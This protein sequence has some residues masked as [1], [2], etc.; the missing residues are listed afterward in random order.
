MEPPAIAFCEAQKTLL[1]RLAAF[2]ADSEARWLLVSVPRKMGTTTALAE[3]AARFTRRD[4]L[5]VTADRSNE[6]LKCAALRSGVPL[7]RM[8][9]RPGQ[10]QFAELEGPAR[11]VQ[12][13]HATYFNARKIA[14]A[15]FHPSERS[16]CT[17]L[18]QLIYF[19]ASGGRPL[20]L[21]T[22]HTHISHVPTHP[23]FVGDPLFAECFADKRVKTAIV[24]VG[25]L[26]ARHPDC[27]ETVEWR[28]IVEEAPR[29]S[30]ATMTLHAC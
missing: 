25:P 5:W 15:V 14:A 4:V 27:P 26:P 28:H 11:Y 1:E 29:G 10:V 16:Y 13:L 9:I 19:T 17:L 7:E 18:E 2:E 22:E 21:M 30:P 24:Y 8:T 23:W 20:L 12:L 3:H 6:P